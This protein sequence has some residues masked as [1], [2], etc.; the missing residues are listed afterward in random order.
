MTKPLSFRRE[1]WK[2]LVSTSSLGK[3]NFYDRTNSSGDGIISRKIAHFSRS[4]FAEMGLVQKWSL[5]KIGRAAEHI[6][7]RKHDN[8]GKEFC[9]L[10]HRVVK[11][12][13]N[14]Q[15]TVECFARKVVAYLSSTLYWRCA[16]PGLRPVSLCFLY[17]KGP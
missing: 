6:E 14:R 15:Y 1:N 13:W 10:R 2:A 9:N 17:Y 4:I 16:G 8:N 3:L 12:L 5:F 7:G 11:F